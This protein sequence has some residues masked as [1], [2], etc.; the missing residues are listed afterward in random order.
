[1]PQTILFVDDEPHVLEALKRAL[2][3]EP[4][5][6]LCA[7]SAD[8][9]LDILNREPV[10]VVVSDEMMP[11]ML[12]S[13]LLAV[14]YRKYPDTVR[15]MLTG[16]ANLEA[17]LR[18]IN[19]GQIY[20]F[21]T[22]PCNDMELRITLRQAI[23]QRELA[24]ESRRL[25]EKFKHH[26]SILEQLETDHPGITRLQRDSEGTIILDDGD[27]DLSA[28]IKEIQEVLEES[29]ERLPDSME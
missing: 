15:I 3:K 11:G 18:A 22:K 5:L 13:E 26:D 6:I 21:L 2:H 4:Y 20:R 24:R 9:A 10:D 7:G 14:V 8:E 27:Y 16:H 19:E 17:A 1:M 29:E 25:L 12:G 28:L 23:Q